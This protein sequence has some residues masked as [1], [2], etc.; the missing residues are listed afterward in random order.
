MLT[1]SVD[2]IHAS[3]MRSIDIEPEEVLAV[4]H[5]IQQFDPI[6]VGYR[7]LAECL[8]IQLNQYENSEAT[9][10]IK[11]ARIIVKDH[12]A[13]L[14]ARDYAQLTSRRPPLP[15]SFRMSSSARTV[16]PGAGAWN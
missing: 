1:I 7:D 14:G 3:L 12:L 2:A 15:I 11:H 8:L 10:A 9:Q 16:I 5:R 13:L 6:G 4:L